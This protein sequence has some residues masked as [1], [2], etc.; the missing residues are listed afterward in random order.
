MFGIPRSFVIVFCWP[1]G[2]FFRSISRIT[3]TVHQTAVIVL[4]ET[5]SSLEVRQPRKLNYNFVRLWCQ[6][7]VNIFKWKAKFLRL[8]IS[9]LALA[10]TEPRSSPQWWSAHSTTADIVLDL[11][12]LTWG[13]DECCKGIKFRTTECLIIVIYWHFRQSPTMHLATISKGAFQTPRFG[14]MVGDIGNANFCC[15]IW[16]IQLLQWLRNCNVFYTNFCG[17]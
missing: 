15:F 14:V 17:L 13:F 2:W 3:K 10:V 16:L 6:V 9:S 11:R 1:T 5:Y 12:S 4:L 7:V 8:M